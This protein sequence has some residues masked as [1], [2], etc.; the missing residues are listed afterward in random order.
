MPAVPTPLPTH[1][2]IG[3]SAEQTSESAPGLQAEGAETPEGQAAE[4]AE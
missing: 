1:L 4:T 2:P 3:D